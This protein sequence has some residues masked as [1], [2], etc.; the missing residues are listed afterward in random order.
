[1]LFQR[2]FYARAMTHLDTL[3]Y[4]VMLLVCVVE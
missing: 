4:G 2:R 3:R 1:M